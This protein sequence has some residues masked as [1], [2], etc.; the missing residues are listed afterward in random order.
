MLTLRLRYQIPQH[1][2]ARRRAD[3][4][5]TPIKQS[6]PGAPRWSS[7]HPLANSV[8]RGTKPAPP[9]ERNER[10]DVSQDDVNHRPAHAPI[11]AGINIPIVDRPSA[12]T[13]ARKAPIATSSKGGTI[14]STDKVQREFVKSKE[15]V[16][17]SSKGGSPFV[18]KILDKPVP[19]NFRLPSLESY[20]GSSDP[21]EQIAAFRAQ[22]VLYDTS[23]S[24]MC[25]A[26]LTTLRG[27]AQ[28]W[29]SQLR[30]S[31]ISS[32]DSLAKEFEFNFLASSRPRPIAALLLS[33]TQ[34]GDE[35]L[36]QFIGRFAIEIR[37]MPDAHP[38]LAIQ[39]FM[40][41]SN[42]TDFSGH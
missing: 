37:G 41:G 29:Y 19:T 30:L 8:D 3:I 38:S 27:L 42:L 9:N 33:L 34:G 16:D 17:E 36:A 31:S 6:M 1:F 23:D 18:P 7:P 40:M 15:E 10:A 28:M 5:R 13:T 21:S 24:L 22:M 14:D 12:S 4:A 2:D 11:N 32:F 25:R 39:A 26:F 20:D 35:P